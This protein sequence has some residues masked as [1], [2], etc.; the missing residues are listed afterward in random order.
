MATEPLTT[1][2]D[3][4]KTVY[5]RLFD[6][7]TPAAPLGWCVTHSAWEA[8]PHDPKIAATEETIAGDADES[9]Y[10][11]TVDLALLY[12]SATPKAF[13]VQAVDDLA[14]DEIISVGEIILSSGRNVSS[15]ADVLSS[16]R[17]TLTQA[18]VLSDATPFAGGLVATIAS[19]VAGLNGEAMRGTDSAALASVATEPRLAEL[20]AANLPGVLDTVAAALDDIKG[21]TWSSATD[22]LEDIRDAI[23]SDLSPSAIWTYILARINA[24]A[25]AVASAQSASETLEIKRGDSFTQ[26]WSLG[27]YAVLDIADVWLSVKE[28]PDDADADAV[29]LLSNTVGLEVFNGAA[30]GTPALGAISLAVVDSLLIATA[31][32]DETRTAQLT[33]STQLGFGVQFRTTG[34]A[35]SEVQSGACKVI[36]DYV[37]ATT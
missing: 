22:T 26:S 33:S 24:L 7:N 2:H 20:D 21:A 14:T 18:H 8:S 17:S 37:K 28:S 3:S 34:G 25:S 27:A 29:L 10:A 11:A 23:D 12:N 35:V 16:T 4:A 1:K 19:D 9:L 13:A 31:T 5:F 36:A 30:E 32:L 6:F 15:N